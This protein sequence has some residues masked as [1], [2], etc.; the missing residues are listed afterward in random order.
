MACI[1]G[2]ALQARQQKDFLPDIFCISGPG[3]HEFRMNQ[4]TPALPQSLPKPVW[5]DASH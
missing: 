2:T 1:N 3:S 4:T 5:F